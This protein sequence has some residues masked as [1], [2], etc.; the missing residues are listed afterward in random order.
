M[1]PDSTRGSCDYASFRLHI[2]DTRQRKSSD[3]SLETRC[4]V[5]K[6]LM[7]KRRQVFAH[8]SKGRGGFGGFCS[9]RQSMGGLLRMQVNAR[10]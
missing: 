4:E 7:I 1:K 6:I 5:G 8:I 2:T 10:G 3:I 9:V